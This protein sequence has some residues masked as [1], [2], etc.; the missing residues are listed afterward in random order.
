MT[1]QVSTNTRYSSVFDSPSLSEGLKDKS[2]GVSH[3]CRKEYTRPDTIKNDV[4]GTMSSSN[5]PSK[6][7]DAQ[8]LR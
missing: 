4:R 7:L 1:I 8:R 2:S 6:S 3:E 5:K